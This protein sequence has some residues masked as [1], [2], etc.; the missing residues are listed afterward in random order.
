MCHAALR[1]TQGPRRARGRG[2]IAPAAGYWRALGTL[3]CACLSAGAPPPRRLRARCGRAPPAW[4]RCPGSP[5]RH[6][7]WPRSRAR[8]PAR[9]GLG[10]KAEAAAGGRAHVFEGH[11]IGNAAAHAQLAR[12]VAEGIAAGQAAR[13]VEVLGFDDAALA[14]QD[15]TA[16]RGHVHRARH[17]RAP[18]V[19]VEQRRRGA[20]VDAAPRLAARPARVGAHAHGRLAHDEADEAQRIAAGVEQRTAAELGVH[21][22]VAL[23]LRE[24]EAEARVHRAHAADG[25]GLQQ[26]DH[27]GRLR[28]EPVRV[29]LQQ[30]D[31]VLARRAEHGLRLGQR[32]GER[33]LA[34]HVLAGLGGVHRPG[35]VQAV[36]QRDVDG[37]D[38]GVGEQRL[39]AAVVA[40][41]AVR[42]GE[43]RR[44][45]GAPA[46]H[47]DDTHA[48]ARCRPAR[49][50]VAEGAGDLGAAQD[51][52]AQG[53]GHGGLSPM[54]SRGG[55]PR[56]EILGPLTQ[57]GVT[58]A[59]DGRA[60]P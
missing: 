25:A 60:G 9:K 29:A 50:M 39:V 8:R 16:V 58:F 10:G 43:G 36:G 37:V 30:H 31:T 59:R 55:C 33:L 40:R 13:V 42:G 5:P 26:R 45:L 20:D 32:E 47:G 18:A 1:E 49:D 41:D 14:E 44:R 12:Q 46:R 35:R 27:V 34:Q 11:R 57:S 56:A 17:Q 51:A 54:G 4:R 21:A 7:R 38:F 3:P 52:Q 23:R 53:F 22:D 48:P 19:G 24:R 2:T 28:L 15:G 6:A